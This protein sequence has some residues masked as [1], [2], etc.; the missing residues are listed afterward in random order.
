MAVFFGGLAGPMSRSAAGTGLRFVG[1]LAE[2]AQRSNDQARVFEAGRRCGRPR[3]GAG[4]RLRGFWP[5]V[6]AVEIVTD[7]RRC[8][9]FAPGMS[10]TVAMTEL[11]TRN[12]MG[13]NGAAWRR[14]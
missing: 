8:L 3:C 10:L 2:V 5:T 1:V 7:P 13:R 9:L 11:A 12:L 4:L 6:T 14:R